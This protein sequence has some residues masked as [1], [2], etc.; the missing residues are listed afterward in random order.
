MSKGLWLWKDVRSCLGQNHE[1]KDQ[2]LLYPEAPPQS[3]PFQGDP[4]E[5]RPA[6]AQT[7]PCGS[8]TSSLQDSASSREQRSPP[9]EQVSLGHLPAELLLAGSFKTI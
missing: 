5:S 8:K 7:L 4:A 3:A 9:V 6:S 2:E 1:K